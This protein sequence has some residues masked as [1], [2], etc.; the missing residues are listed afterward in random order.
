MTTAN[1]RVIAH[2]HA[3]PDREAEVVNLLKELAAASR[4]EPA[5]LSYEVFTS[6]E[7]DR[8]I[9]IL[10]TYADAE[11]FA[12]HRV[13]EHFERIGRVRILPLLTRRVIEE[14]SIKALKQA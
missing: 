13:S 8:H 4:E 2:Y 11:G 5:N 10:E 7:D 6:V 3:K 1:H 12:A 9:V 14:Y